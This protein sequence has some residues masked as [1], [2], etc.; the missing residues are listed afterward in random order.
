M[1]YISFTLPITKSKNILFSVTKKIYSPYSLVTEINLVL[2]DS[3]QLGTIREDYEKCNSVYHKGNLL[4]L[5]F[6]PFLN[7]G[8]NFLKK[9]YRRFYLLW[10]ILKENAH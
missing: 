4:R 9:E 2:G 5:S 10:N 3:V 8:N 7:S 1:A 6:S